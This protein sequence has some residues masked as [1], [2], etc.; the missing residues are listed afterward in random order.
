M[1]EGAVLLDLIFIKLMFGTY[2]CIYWGGLF[3][4][5]FSCGASA[6]LVQCALGGVALL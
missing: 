5:L 2:M 4:L 1:K 3:P 6:A